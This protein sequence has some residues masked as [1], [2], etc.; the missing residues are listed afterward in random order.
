MGVA[1][2]TIFLD[3]LFVFL[4]PYADNA[5][6]EIGSKYSLS[7]FHLPLSAVSTTLYGCYL[8]THVYLVSLLL[9][10]YRKRRVLLFFVFL[11]PIL[12]YLLWFVVPFRLLIERT[13]LCLLFGVNI[14]CVCAYSIRKYRK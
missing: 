7:F 10:K 8:A 13:F 2:I 9:A 1:G 12:S 6:K 4:F 3:V 14:T 11:M 5:L